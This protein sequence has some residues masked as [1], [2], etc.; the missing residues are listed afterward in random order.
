MFVVVNYLLHS[1]I[2]LFM[3]FTLFN[4]NLSHSD[5][6]AYLS[7]TITYFTSIKYQFNI[8]KIHYELFSEKNMMITEGGFN[9]PLF[10]ILDK[11]NICS[12]LNLI[13]ILHIFLAQEISNILIIL[14]IF[15]NVF[16]LRITIL[17]YKSYV[18]VRDEIYN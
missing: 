11:I 1:G 4:N 12:F 13:L 10:W 5:L 17:K 6:V 15:V 14:S 7:L 18:I 9:N 2:A 8:L 3:L 16:D